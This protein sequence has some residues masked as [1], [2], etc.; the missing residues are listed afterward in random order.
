L[1]IIEHGP[2]KKHDHPDHQPTNPGCLAAT[3]EGLAVGRAFDEAR[4]DQLRHLPQRV[5]SPWPMAKVDEIAHIYRD[6]KP[7]SLNCIH[8]YN[9]K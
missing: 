8:I 1:N 4:V 5:G 9:K 6:D 7:A 3:W 2:L